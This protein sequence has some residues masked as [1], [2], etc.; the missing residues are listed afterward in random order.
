MTGS[1]HTGNNESRWKQRLSAWMPDAPGIGWRET[2]RAGAGAFFGIVVAG[3]FGQWLPGDGVLPWLIAPVGASAVLVF[4]VPASPLAQPW[5]VAGSA[6]VATVVAVSCG[7]WLGPTLVAAALAV[8]LTILL[9]FPLRCVHP[10]AGAIALLI[11]LA[12]GDLKARGYSLLW[13]PVLANVLGLLAAGL[14]FHRLTGYRYP[15]GPRGQT[16]KEGTPNTLPSLLA[17]DLDQALGEYGEFLDV[18]RDDLRALF[19]LVAVNALHRQLG[20][21]TC[22][23]VMT[24]N[25][26]AV[27]FGDYLDETWALFM[28][29]RFKAIPVVDRARRVI[30]IVT[31]EDILRR[32]GIDNRRRAVRRVRRFVS[33]GDDIHAQKPEVVG[34]VMSSPVITLGEDTPLLEA[35][36]IFSGHGHSHFP[37]VDADR[38]LSGI[39]ARSDIL[40]AI[41]RAL[42]NSAGVDVTV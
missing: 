40:R 27:E 6:L 5:P 32:A 14:V 13:Y 11:A 18:S 35:V 3:L 22:G 17:R 1:D 24:C 36:D 9:M 20:E 19:R 39:I 12:E 26:V 8:G 28:Q 21:M 37:V 31:R 7:L 4:A 25:P 16:A 38:K 15:H 42:S 23:E 10:P 30:G 34:Q 2:F 33:R 41:F 29:H